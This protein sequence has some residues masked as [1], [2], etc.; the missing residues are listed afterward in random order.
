MANT[1]QLL[2]KDSYFTTIKWPVLLISI[3]VNLYDFHLHENPP[4]PGIGTYLLQRKSA[5][6]PDPKTSKSLSRHF[7]CCPS[8]FS[9]HAVT[10]QLAAHCVVIDYSTA[11]CALRPQDDSERLNKLLLINKEIFLYT[12]RIKCCLHCYRLGSLWLL[13]LMANP[14]FFPEWSPN[15]ASLTQLSRG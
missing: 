15:S 3:L 12:A 11:S 7:G 14:V 6:N 13:F 8:A 2:Q 10:A 4:K 1:H 5:E 9:S